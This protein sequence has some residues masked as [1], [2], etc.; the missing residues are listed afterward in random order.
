M[1]RYIALFSLLQLAFVAADAAAPDRVTRK[2][3]AARTRA[4]PGNMHRLADPRFDQGPV[5]PAMAMDDM[6]LVFKSSSEQ[7]SE[8]DRLLAEQQNPSSAVYHQWLN[9][10]EFGNRFGVSPS[11]HSKVVA[12]LTSEGFRVNESGRAR[13]WVAFSGTAAQVSRALHTSIHRFRVDGETH[14]ANT[15]DPSVPEALSEI[16]GG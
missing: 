3:D 6:I 10:E 4:V 8:L 14:F 12:W 1:S 11:D 13:N 7:Q 15:G 16:P 2:V 5:D 9:P